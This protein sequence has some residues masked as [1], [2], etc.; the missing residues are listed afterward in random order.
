MKK[1]W[2][3]AYLTAGKELDGLEEELTWEC[4]PWSGKTKKKPQV[5]ISFTIPAHLEPQSKFSISF[6]AAPQEDRKQH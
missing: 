3:S 4:Q 5:S 2:K 6:Q 1:P